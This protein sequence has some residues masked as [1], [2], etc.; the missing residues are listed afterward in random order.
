MENSSSLSKLAGRVGML[1]VLVG[2]ALFF[3]GIFGAPRTLA[4]VGLALMVVSMAAF[5]F[6]EFAPGKTSSR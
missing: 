1:F 2:C 6:E 3:A 4:F 5:A